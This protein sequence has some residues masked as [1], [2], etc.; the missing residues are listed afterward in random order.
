[1]SQLIEM[2]RRIKAIETTQKITHAMQLVAM[3]TRLRLREKNEHLE[4]YQQA[5]SSLF[6]RARLQVNNWQHPVLFPHTAPESNPLL[7]IVGAHKG[8]CGT[9]NTNLVHWAAKHL[10]DQ[11]WSHA[12]VMVIGK[13]LHDYLPS[14]MSSLPFKINLIPTPSDLTTE[15]SESLAAT[16]TNMILTAQPNYSTVKIL[17][18]YPIGFFVQRQQLMTLVPFNIAQDE[19]VATEQ[20]PFLWENDPQEIV[21]ALADIQIRTTM[22]YLL[23]QSLLA[24]HAARFV[25]M[26]GATRNAKN[27]KEVMVLQFNKLRQW[28]ITKE[29]T[30]LSSSF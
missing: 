6:N 29:L 22:H 23:L 20:E 19:P 24:E 16:L 27:L 9:F 1:M 11:G 15:T 7:I 13:K 30:E 3:S 4:Q 21:T 12:S 17:H 25:S 8:L 28:R 5:V 2:R 14:L 10:Q 18:S 26:D